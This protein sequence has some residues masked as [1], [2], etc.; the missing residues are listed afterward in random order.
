MEEIPRMRIVLTWRGKPVMEGVKSVLSDALER[1]G[2]SGREMA[3]G[4][5]ETTRRHFMTR[6]PGSAHYSPERVNE[7]ASHGGVGEAVID[8][9]G[10]TRAFRDVDIFP[11]NGRALSIPI[12]SDAYGRSPREMGDLF[13]VRKRDGRAFL[14]RHGG[15]SL[16]FLYVLK[17]HVRQ[18]MDRTMMPGLERLAASAADG[19]V[20]SLGGSRDGK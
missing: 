5:V 20:S 19:A 9:P 12:H 11:R 7:G 14:A 10:I 3:R 8:A 16:V 6:W 13:V 4:M 2:R 1:L 18:R 15:G 17:R